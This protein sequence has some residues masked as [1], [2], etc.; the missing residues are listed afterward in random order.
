MT[1]SRSN[2]LYGPSKNFLLK[3]EIKTLEGLIGIAKVH[4]VSISQVMRD[5]LRKHLKNEPV[6]A[7]SIPTRKPRGWW[8]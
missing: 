1:I 2:K 4:G 3:V 5:A 8:N 7:P 6:S